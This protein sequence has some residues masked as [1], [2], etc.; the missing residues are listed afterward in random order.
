VPVE[1]ILNSDHCGIVQHADVGHHSP[2]TES[3]HQKFRLLSALA[4]HIV[5]RVGPID[6]VYLRESL[7][8]KIVL[9]DQ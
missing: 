4:V 3:V 1:N 9:L 7:M 8:I 6:D 5:H 2:G